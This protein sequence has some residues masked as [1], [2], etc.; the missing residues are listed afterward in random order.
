V[1]RGPVFAA[2][3]QTRGAATG[4]IVVVVVVAA[5]AE[6]ETV[7]EVVGYGSHERYET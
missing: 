6:T 4:G 5:A 7:T 3:K 2:A 1:Q